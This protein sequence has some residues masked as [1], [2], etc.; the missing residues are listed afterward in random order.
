MRMA[1]KG[2]GAGRCMD[3]WLA[4]AGVREAQCHVVA[5]MGEGAPALHPVGS[6]AENAVAV[7]DYV[8]QK[9]EYPSH[10]CH[11]I[12]QAVAHAGR[13]CN[14]RKSRVRATRC[15]LVKRQICQLRC[16]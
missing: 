13:C 6:Q 10:G 15:S 2:V 14:R 16:G 1:A 9:M 3:W 12:F 7:R 4:A 5:S 11:W 8:T